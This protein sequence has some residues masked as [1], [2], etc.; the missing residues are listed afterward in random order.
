M[1]WKPP[2]S[3][4]V[5]Q[6]AFSSLLSFS[7]FNVT[8]HPP[9]TAS[10]LDERRGTDEERDPEAYFSCVGG[11]RRG[12]QQ[13]LSPR[14]EQLPFN[15]K[16]GKLLLWF[17]F[18]LFIPQATWA[19]PED[20][21]VFIPLEFRNTASGGLVYQGTEVTPEEAINLHRRGVDI[22]R[23]NPRE[24]TD[25]WQNKMGQ[26]LS[27]DTLLLD[28]QREVEFLSTS[29]RIPGTIEFT[30]QQ[31]DSLGIP[32][33]Y[34]VR[35]SRK[36]HNVLLRKAMLRKIGYM[37]P[38]SQ[39]IRRLQVR[40]KKGDPQK[41]NRFLKK[42]LWQHL[43]ADPARWIRNFYGIKKVQVE[44]MDGELVEREKYLFLP[45][46]V[47]SD[48]PQAEQLAQVN[49]QETLLEFQDVLVYPITNNH[50][51][52][53]SLGFSPH[54]VNQDLRLLNSVIVAYALTDVPESI[55]K[56]SW[57]LGRVKDNFLVL[58]YEEYP[59]YSESYRPNYEDT[60]WIMRRIAQL[61]R[62]DF[63]EM[64]QG[65]RYPD[66]IAVV[67]QEKLIARR[68]YLVKKLNLEFS[69]L[70]H[71][72]PSELNSEHVVE[73]VVSK[74]FWTGY[75]ARFAHTQMDSPLSNTEIF[76][77]FKSKLLSNL[78]SN[79]VRRVNKEQ[80]SMDTNGKWRERQIQ[81]AEKNFHKFLETG[82]PQQTPMGIW[83]QPTL[84]GRLILSR[85]IVTGV[86]QGAANDE[87]QPNNMIH[88]ADT[89]GFSV[90]AG[91]LGTVEGL[92]VN[93]FADLSGNVFFTRSYT[94]LKPLRSFKQSLK[95]PLRHIFV[96]SYKGD[97]AKSLDTFED[98]DKNFRV[99][100]SLIITDTIGGALGARSGYGDPVNGQFQVKLSNS[101]VVIHRL[102]VY[103][104]DKNTIHVYQDRG[105]INSLKLSLGWQHY[106]PVIGLSFNINNG[107]AKVLFHR[108][109]M[110]PKPS[111]NPFLEDNLRNLKNILFTGS[112]EMF[113][114][115]PVA[116][117]HKFRE[118]SFHLNLLFYR[119]TSLSFR[120]RITVTHPDGEKADFVR[121]SLGGRS[122]Q[123]WEGLG[124]DIINAFISERLDQDIIF[125][126]AGNNNPGDSLRGNSRFRQVY[127]DSL[128]K[129]G[130]LT[131]NFVQVHH[132]WKG[133]ELSAEGVLDI[134]E[135]INSRFDYEFFP[136]EVLANTKRLL[137]Y[138]IDLKVFV[139]EP[140]IE[141]LLNVSRGETER[142]LP[143]LDNFQQSDEHGTPSKFDEFERNQQFCKHQ[144]RSKGRKHALKSCIQMVD[145]VEKHANSTDD[146]IAFF[147]GR[148]NFRIEAKILGYREGD[149]EAYE[150]IASHVFGE[151]GAPKPLGPIMQVLRHPKFQMSQGE[152]L[153]FWLINKL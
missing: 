42:V 111:E 139:Y 17:A 48:D 40:F 62:E 53:L 25:I 45:P 33:I 134:V 97:I 60:L 41:R 113:Q 81:Q 69:E 58:P 112:L 66:E 94:H 78:L 50:V 77:F 133:W 95:E 93:H 2:E 13:S 126:R 128:I 68:N 1:N 108:L 147:G 85:E 8:T 59:H 63:E 26:P 75:G 67:V 16:L 114:N 65:A 6:A 74:E 143:Y 7:P 153:I 14:G 39:H 142:L 27:T 47:L 29:M 119:W 109:N 106:I 23:L 83:T 73:G 70:T 146:L 136:P 141:H 115:S 57:H 138:I 51:L 28:P 150:P 3:I 131:E 11:K 36:I 79:L 91:L 38:P 118:S 61:R 18:S 101:Q 96:N 100:E 127:F 56:F 9:V 105:N 86:Y 72:E 37:V 30:V 117:E 149:E 12:R 20:V 64:A 46:G 5:F 89:F 24:G 84:N 148:R 88:L 104:A 122:G 71:R 80:L 55:N 151:V 107:S 98:F 49:P 34:V 87:D 124:T 21:S 99:G 92:P 15:F 35:V 129:D 144:M 52:D 140:A 19:T 43:A 32:H 103:R 22:S 110:T 135:K 31:K 120:D 132:R 4:K 90:N 130:R 116:V 54:S 152:F 123:D 102:H 125:A 76:A 82:K 121:G 44:N 10:P 137:L 145:F